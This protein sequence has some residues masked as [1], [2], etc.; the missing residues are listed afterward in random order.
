MVM[1]QSAFEAAVAADN[2]VVGNCL[3]GM[4]IFDGDYL[5]TDISRFPLP[6]KGRKGKD[7]D[8]CLCYVK[9]GKGEELTL[10]AKVYI[11]VWGTMQLVG[12][13]YT[14][15]VNHAFSPVAIISTVRAVYAP[16][17]TLRWE[18]DLSDYPRSLGTVST[19]RGDN[20]SDPIPLEAA[21]QI[22]R[23]ERVKATA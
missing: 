20:V 9:S 23:V 11:G 2:R 12:T 4:G 6:R 16:D 18:K 13:A 21:V 8:V 10:M 15:R 22:G 7:S 3:E 14:D 1:Y 5:D 19:I 17:G